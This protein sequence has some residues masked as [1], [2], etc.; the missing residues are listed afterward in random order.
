VI[1]NPARR[2]AP[3]NPNVTQTTNPAPAQP[4]RTGRTRFL[5]TMTPRTRLHH[6]PTAHPPD[7]VTTTAS[8]SYRV[9]VHTPQPWHASGSTTVVASGRATRARPLPRCPGCP[10]CL[11]LPP[12]PCRPEPSGP[13][14]CGPA[15]AACGASA[16][17]SAPARAPVA[18]AAGPS[19]L[20]GWEEFDESRPAARCNPASCTRR[21]SIS[22][23][24]SASFALCTTTSATSSSYE[25]D[26][27]ESDT[28]RS[29]T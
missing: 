27:G 1:G 29:Q 7:V 5:L 24:C 13:E 22:V 19:W 16:S 26:T 20:G 15:P 11:R 25:G 6:P 14:P 23:A 3:D 18:F 8:S 10:P 17:A 28:I 12:P 2:N 4:I 9:T 21:A